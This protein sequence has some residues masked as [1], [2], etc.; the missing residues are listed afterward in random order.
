M[1]LTG[2]V[3]VQTPSNMGMARTPAAPRLPRCGSKSC[4]RSSSS[5][6]SCRWF[7]AYSADGVLCL[8]LSSLPLRIQ[9]GNAM[10]TLPARPVELTEDEP[11]TK[12][13]R[14]DGTLDCR[15]L[16]PGRPSAKLAQMPADLPPEQ[17]EMAIKVTAKLLVL[18][19]KRRAQAK[20][21]PP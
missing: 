15:V 16:P 5:R 10:Q 11:A 13:A 21:V 9:N 17:I 6:L 7:H 3:A 8:T 1:A 12:P 19:A 4:K 14:S 18:R 20:R 2:S